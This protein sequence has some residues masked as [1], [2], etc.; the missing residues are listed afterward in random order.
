M[1]F[2]GFLGKDGHS[3]VV[4]IFAMMP[5]LKLRIVQFQDKTHTTPKPRLWLAFRYEDKSYCVLSTITSQELKL[6]FYYKNDESA[7]KSVVRITENE[8]NPPLTM[9]SFIDCNIRTQRH[10]RT[11]KDLNEKHIDWSIGI[12]VRP[13][14]IPTEIEKRIISA[15]V[16]SPFTSEDI[17]SAFKQKHN[18]E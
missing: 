12:E 11:F 15:I 13:E 6:A 16:S 10:I 4:N 3:T 8:F 7:A 14:K 9:L 5:L 1:R 2:K 18:I 17:K